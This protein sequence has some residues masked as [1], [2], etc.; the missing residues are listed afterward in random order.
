MAANGDGTSV[1]AEPTLEDLERCRKEHAREL[2]RLERMS[3]AQFEA[4][5][6]NFELGRLD[7]DIT[8]LQAIDVLRSM[9]RTNL[10][11][12]Q[13]KKASIRGDPGAGRPGRGNVGGNTDD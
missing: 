5:K 1:P 10:S 9:L 8:R 12:Q 7:P 6:R 4:F 11:L 2:K 13:E 3:D